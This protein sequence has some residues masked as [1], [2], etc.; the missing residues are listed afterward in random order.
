MDCFRL[1]ES[2]KQE[3]TIATRG[4]SKL[5]HMLRKERADGESEISGPSSAG[6]PAVAPSSHPAN[7]T[8]QRPVLEAAQV[9]APPQAHQ[10]IQDMNFRFPVTGFDDP[11]P[12]QWEEW[13]YSSLGNI[14]FDV[15]LDASEFEALFQST[16]GSNQM[17]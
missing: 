13:D 12:Y 4:L 15:N 6:A 9:P 1:L 3:C 5:R 8:V 14:N 10:H 16:E 17:F 2:S 11:P 7:T